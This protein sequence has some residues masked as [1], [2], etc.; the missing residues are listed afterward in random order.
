MSDVP[1][2]PTTTVSAE[3][4]AELSS[5]IP[6]DS[7]STEADRLDG[8]GRDETET[9]CFPPAVVAWP[10]S[11]EEVADLL[12]WASHYR[13]PVT[14][15]GARTGLSGG[16]LPVHG[17]V[18]LSLERMNRIREIDADDQ[19]AIVEAGVRTADLQR[20]AAERG[21]YYPPDPASR[22]TC[23]LGGNLAED[24]AGP[25]SCLYGTTRRYVLGL[26]AVLADGSLLDTGGRNRKDA[27][28]Y[29][30][31]QLLVGSEGTLAVLT[32]ATLRLIRPPRARL[33]VAL[34][35]PSVAVAAGAVPACFSGE[36][37]VAA[38][39]L[40]DESALTLVREDLDVSVLPEASSLLLLDLDGEEDEALL[41][42][43]QQIA[44]ATGASESAVAVDPRDRRRLWNL[45][46]GVAPA[47]RK[48]SSYKE[49]DAV[50]PRSRVG[51]LAA[52]AY[53][54]AGG[55][56]LV[57]V[58][59]GHAGDG[60]LHVNLLRGDLPDSEWELRRT[61]AEDALVAGVLALGGAVTGEHGIGWTQRRHLTTALD[62]SA[63]GLLDGIKRCFDPLGILN[64]GKI[65]PGSD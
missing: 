63:L 11:R 53:R 65:L 19:V 35:F 31:T 18:A 62:E 64:P 43:A 36:V 32:A 55:Q 6:A 20:A 28:G 9:H 34:G 58:C 12:G 5:L 27:T 61:A 1:P 8:Y 57:A 37:D 13:I 44:V 7:Y 14:P 51:E 33:T 39:E 30:L 46:E 26:E 21:L 22:E 47:V 2:A 17:G 15:Q 16:A 24:S 59:Y 49:V 48:R 50:V 25:H 41:E 23:L 10:E 45:R 29:D 42:A 60:N 52:L 54:A 40:L 56:R 38:C 3:A 4:L